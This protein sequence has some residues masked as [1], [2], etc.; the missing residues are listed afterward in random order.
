MKLTN[1]ILLFIFITIFIMSN[2]AH[3]EK[4][5]QLTKFVNEEV[6]NLSDSIER[7][8]SITKEAELNPKFTFKQFLIRVQ[9]AVG[10]EVPWTATLQIVPEIELLWEKN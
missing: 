10:I 7:E 1:N 5:P 9:M 4:V 8:N 6:V 2:Y 3:A